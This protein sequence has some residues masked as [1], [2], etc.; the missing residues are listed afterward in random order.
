MKVHHRTHNSP[1]PVPVLS[2]SNPI[3]TVQI[4]LPKI[5]FPVLRLCQII[6]PDPRLYGVF[7]NKYWVLRGRVVS[8][9]PNLQAEGPPTVGCLR[10]LIQHIR[11]YPP[12]LEAVSSNR[13]PRTRHAVV[14]VDPLNMGFRLYKAKWKMDLRLRSIW[15]V[16]TKII[17]LL[18]VMKHYSWSKSEA[19]YSCLIHTHNVHNL[20]K[21]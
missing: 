14:T 8:P 2:L 10:L 1:P 5:H 17:F 4:N 12:Y 16:N 20:Y 11:S 15:A 18:S 6:H 9:P 7:R 13:N 19:E 3:H 21:E